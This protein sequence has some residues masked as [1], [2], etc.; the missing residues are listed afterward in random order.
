[1]E[2][3][4]IEKKMIKAW[5]KLIGRS[6]YGP[7]CYKVWNTTSNGAPYYSWTFEITLKS[8]SCEI[9]LCTFRRKDADRFLKMAKEFNVVKI[10]I[11]LDYPGS[12][13]IDP[14]L[15]KQFSDAENIW[16][17]IY[18][19]T[20]RK[21]A[22]LHDPNVPELSQF[23]IRSAMLTYVDVLEVN[24]GM[25]ILVR[26]VNFKQP[27]N[28]CEFSKITVKGSELNFDRSASC[29]ILHLEE[30]KLPENLEVLAVAEFDKCD[31]DRNFGKGKLRTV[32]FHD[33]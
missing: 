11:G 10:S 9:D 16:L 20:I 30:S 12:V 18:D 15:L 17:D 7:S 23:T 19:L 26:G 29:L 8:R 5:E 13:G 6:G 27:N 2:R 28:Y 32:Q 4:I 22:C 31:V 21:H 3:K 1:M 25:Q 14:W 33:C 24:R